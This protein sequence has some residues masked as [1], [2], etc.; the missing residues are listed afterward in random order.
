[1]RSLISV[2]AAM[3]A[4][5]GLGSAANAKTLIYCSE[6]APEGFDPAPHVT[7]A[8]FDASSQLF[9]NRLVEFAPGTTNAVPGLATGWDISADGKQYTFHLRQGVKFQTTAYFTPSA[10]STPMTSSSAWPDSSTARTPGSIMPAA[11][12]RTTRAWTW[13]G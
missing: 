13:T 1:M 3:V 4:L 6:A 5:A 12:G 2:V 7:G 11:S 8:T 9:Y 10:T